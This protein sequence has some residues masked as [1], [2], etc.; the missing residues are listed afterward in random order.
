MGPALKKP[1]VQVVLEGEPSADFSQI[2]I[3]E[4][5]LQHMYLDT[6]LNQNR[7]WIVLGA[8]STMGHRNCRVVWHLLYWSLPCSSPMMVMCNPSELLIYN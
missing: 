7:A 1:I 2:S 3:G 6:V 5:S 8:R 4:P